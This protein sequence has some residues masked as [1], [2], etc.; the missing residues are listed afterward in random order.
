MNKIKKCFYIIIG[1][2]ALALGAV[3]VV[4][5]VL[6]TTPFLLLASLCFV[7]GSDKFD[8]WFKGTKLYKKH[9]DGFVKNREMTLKQKIVI[10]VF[11]DTMMMI[12]VILID[13]TI[14]RISILLVIVVK[15][16]YFIFRIKTVKKEELSKDVV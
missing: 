6:P 10:L 15:L 4:L 11:A 14:M 1:F 13:S 16:W 3:G 5:P 8:R 7:R 9:L 2:I 12:P